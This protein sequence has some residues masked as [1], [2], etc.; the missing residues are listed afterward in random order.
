ME[1]EKYYMKED[2]R[3]F[4]YNTGREMKCAL[5]R[6][7]HEL[8]HPYYGCSVM[9][10]TAF[11]LQLETGPD[12]CPASHCLVTAV[13]GGRQDR[14]N[15]YYHKGSQYNDINIVTHLNTDRK[16]L[17]AKKS[18]T[19]HFGHKITGIILYIKIRN[20]QFVQN[21]N[22]SDIRSD[23]RA[24]DNNVVTKETIVGGDTGHVIVYC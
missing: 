14:D 9:I 20:V 5:Y 4:G 18:F 24:Q 23:T 11:L 1:D 10:N 19:E 16:H 22:H 3:L 7:D 2:A 12:L 13:T 17:L 6:I 15:E 21:N 8:Q